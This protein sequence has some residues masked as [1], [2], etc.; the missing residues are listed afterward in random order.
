MK[1][2]AFLLLLVTMTTCHEP[3]QVVFQWNTIDVIW[4][5]EEKQN[6]ATEHGDY[7]PANNFIAGI[8][9][10]KGK[11]Y[12]TVPR[13]KSGVPVTL[14]VTSATVVNGNTAPKLEA[15]PNWDMQEV[16]D[17]N[18][19]QLVQSMEIDP[20]GRMWVLDSGKMSPLSVEVKITCP[21]RLVIL[22]LENNGEILRIY[23]FPPQVARHGTAHLNDIVLDHEDGGMAYITDSDREDPGIIVYSLSN[24]TSWKVRHDSMKA[25]PE[26]VRFMVSKNL[27]N[28]PISV[29]GIAL[30]P[31]SV[32]DRQVY[33]SPLSSFHLYS[34]PTSVLKSNL[35]NV[36]E[37]VKELGKKISQ[38][39]GMMMSAKG[40][41]YFGLLADDAVA[42]W[43]TKQSF[44]TGQRVISRDH[45]RMQWPDTFA[46]DE[47]GNFYCVT[48]SLQNILTNRVNTSVPN[49]RVVRAKTAVKSYQYLEDGTAP[50]QPEIPTSVAN[51]ISLAVATVSTI[52]LAFVVV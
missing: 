3:F 5:S 47:N 33:Y 37:H 24:N 25:K 32:E 12:L 41:L 42:M 36:D 38:T 6:Y 10:W 26:A 29:D 16:G 52:L 17:C 27:I 28:M 35:S 40:A 19:F 13:W 15:F 49:Y 34:I 11:M 30:S 50:E 1:S 18:A 39:D 8:K 44:T 43:D 48:N 46:F 2:S 22:D 9:F 14:G 21:P 20:K 7:I 23:E 45:E 31:A 51:R 4:P